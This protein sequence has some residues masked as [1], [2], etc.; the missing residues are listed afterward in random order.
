[1]SIWFESVFMEKKKEEKTHACHE[2]RKVKKGKEK[3]QTHKER[4]RENMRKK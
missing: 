1:M 3:R 2:K 4:A